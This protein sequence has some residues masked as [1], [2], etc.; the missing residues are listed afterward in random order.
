MNGSAGAR[1]VTSLNEVV[2]V[3]LETSAAFIPRR[4]VNFEDAA[5]TARD[6]W[7]GSTSLRVCACK[8]KQFLYSY[9]VERPL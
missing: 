5:V 3:S 4:E 9:E 7:M 2:E 8:M 6:H 1:L